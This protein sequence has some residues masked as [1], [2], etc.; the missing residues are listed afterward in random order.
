MRAEFRNQ[1]PV[2]RGHEG[3][4]LAL[5][6]D[7]E[8][9]CSRL[10]ATGGQPRTDLAPQHGRHLVAV[11]AIQDAAR[12]LRVDERAVDVAS[13]VPGV[14]D[15]FLRDL[16]EHHALHRNLRVQHLEQVPGDRLPLAVLISGEV[17]LVGV[18]ERAFQVGDGLA[19]LLGDDV[20]GLETVLDID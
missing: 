14:L 1:I 16:V 9:R 13:V 3:E 12:L 17:E 10:H 5:P 7:D 4:A 11:Q 8:P 18:L 20:V 15:G 19:L 6:V 2:A